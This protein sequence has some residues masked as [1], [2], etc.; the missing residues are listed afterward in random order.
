MEPQR[1]RWIAAGGG[2]A[3]SIISIAILRVFTILKV[4]NSGIS[5]SGWSLKTQ[6]FKNQQEKNCDRDELSW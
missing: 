3:V 1:K 6:S 2:R 5:L 4:M